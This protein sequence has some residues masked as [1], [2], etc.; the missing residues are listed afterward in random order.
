MNSP[1]TNNISFV[2]FQEMVD[3]IT[4]SIL[5]ANCSE[6]VKDDGITT[7]DDILSFFNLFGYNDATLSL[8][9]PR[10]LD[11]LTALNLDTQLIDNYIDQ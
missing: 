8:A 5:S 9:W 11:T 7:L 2:G 3:E 1:S 4:D 6:S 10:L